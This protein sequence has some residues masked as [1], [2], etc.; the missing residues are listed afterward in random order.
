MGTDK[1]GVEMCSKGRAVWTTIQSHLQGHLKQ[2]LVY[3]TGCKEVV[4]MAQQCS[5]TCTGYWILERMG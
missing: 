2:E 1:A 5:V 3:R 4:G